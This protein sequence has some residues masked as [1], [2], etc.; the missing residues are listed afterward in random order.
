MMQQS[1]LNLKFS[2]DRKL[3]YKFS[4]IF[5]INNI[6]FEINVCLIRFNV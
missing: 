2:M 5:T 4:I 3:K 1:G 6:P